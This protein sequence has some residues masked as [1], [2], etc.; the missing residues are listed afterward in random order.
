MKIIIKVVA[1]R[2]EHTLPDVVDVEQSAFVQ[3]RLIIDNALI[4]MECFHWT[5]KKR[6][7]KKVVI[8]LKLD[9]SKAYDRLEWIF[10]EKTLTAMGYPRKMVELIMR[11][12]SSISYQILING[13]PSTSFSPERGLRQGDPLSPYLF[14]LCADVFFGLIHK[15]VS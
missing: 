10:V 13:Q 11:C 1:N 5:K 14:I 9:M 2:I 4:A 8:A 7:G 12:I 3:G 6:K 15:K